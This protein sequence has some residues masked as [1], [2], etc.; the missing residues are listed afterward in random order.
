VVIIGDD[1]LRTDPAYTRTVIESPEVEHHPWTSS[2][3][4][5]MRHLDV[6]V[7]PAYREPFG[8]VLAEAMAVGTPVVA[9]R[10]DGLPEVVQDGVSGRLVEPHDPG[11][12]AAAVLDVLS[13]RTQMS[14]A[15]RERAQRFYVDGYVDRIEALI[16]G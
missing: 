11:A 14:A 16:S 10:V 5:L 2:A 8:T 9:T 15:A 6:L 7:L 13:R 12:I 3:P 4:G 1:A